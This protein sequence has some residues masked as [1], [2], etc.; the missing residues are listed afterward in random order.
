[1]PFA[2]SLDRIDSGQ[3]YLKGN[4]R[5]VCTI[6]NFALN[7]WG[8]SVL[9]RLAHGVVA[10]EKQ[11]ERDWFRHQRRKLR[12]A[13]KLAESMTGARSEERRVGKECVSTCRSR[14]SP[15]H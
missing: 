15:S 8:D 3:G 5:L 1:M 14:G 10:T 4:V 11:V 13:E 9:R 6:A 12:K 7:Q 2:P